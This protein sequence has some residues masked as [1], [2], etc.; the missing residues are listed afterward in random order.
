MQI[1]QLRYF[2]E[3]ARTGSMNQAASNLFISQPNLSKAIVNLE[4]EFKI[5]IFDRTNRGV[6]L[7]K[8]GKDF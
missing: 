2:I 7:T 5:K 4:E 8:E 1:N 3:V 6:K